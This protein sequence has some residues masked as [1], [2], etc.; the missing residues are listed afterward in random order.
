M[1]GLF[2]GF[3]YFCAAK[4]DIFMLKRPLILVSN[5]DGVYSQGI[6]EL[7][8]LMC[9]LGDVIVVAPDAARS[10]AAC[11]IT[12]TRP[13]SL[14]LLSKKTDLTVY[15]CNGTPVDCVKLALEKAVPRKPDLMVSGINHGDNASVNLYYSGTMGAVLEACMKGVPAVGYSL[16]TKDKQCD[17]KPYREAVLSVAG[18]VLAEGLPHDVCVNVNFPMLPA[19]KGQ[20]VCRMAKGIWQSEWQE[21]GE[22]TY[23]LTGTFTNLEPEAEDTDY[24]ALDHGYAS[25]TPLQLDMTC[26][27]SLLSMKSLQHLY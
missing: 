18:F 22:N 16:R 7:M 10:G 27:P 3:Y 15:A 4:L 26:I 23:R 6:C 5:D 1:L 14:K 11:S 17:F 12:S 9:T 8:G 13:V 24:W 25:I 2:K 19:L 21:D 20:K